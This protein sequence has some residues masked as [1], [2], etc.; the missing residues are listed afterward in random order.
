MSNSPILS[1]PRKMNHENFGRFLYS[2]L[3]Y[4]HSSIQ[5]TFMSAYYV[6]GTILGAGIHHWKKT[7]KFLHSFVLHLV[8]GNR[9]YIY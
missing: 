7:L 5:I 6:P 9:Y 8:K 3:K 2:L 1:L 4:A